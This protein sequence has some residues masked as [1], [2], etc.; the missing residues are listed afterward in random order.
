MAKRLMDLACES[1]LAL[2]LI[3]II[4]V[5]KAYKPL[6]PYETGSSSM[7]VGHYIQK[8]GIDLYYYDE[9]TGDA[10]SKMC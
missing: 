3:I 5:G 2:Q 4:I 10:A 9:Q 1:Y 8:E 6:V 7:L